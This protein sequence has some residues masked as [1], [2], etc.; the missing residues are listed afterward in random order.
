MH[1]GKYF[2]LVIGLMFL[3]ACGTKPIM[4]PVKY[5]KPIDFH[6]KKNALL[7]WELGKQYAGTI[8]SQTQQGNGLIGA[9]AMATMDSI[10]RN[11]NPSRYT[12]SYGKAEQAIFM[13]SFKDV[14]QQNQV[15]KSVELIHEAKSPSANEVLIDIFFK[16]SRTSGASQNFRI[17]LTVMMTITTRNG[18]TFQRTYLV[19]S[20]PEISS[21]F[22]D[23]QSGVSKR[24]LEKLVGGI[25]EWHSLAKKGGKS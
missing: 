11:N 6:V 18:S 21:S 4:P 8:P 5:D 23:Q 20:E 1:L 22:V 2:V 19:Q 24:L 7:K 14:L 25:E 16:S 13:T 17:T 10:D 9:L 12:V 15:F 3:T